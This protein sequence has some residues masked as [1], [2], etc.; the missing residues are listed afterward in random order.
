VLTITVVDGATATDFRLHGSL[1]ASSVDKVRAA[2]RDRSP[3][4]EVSLDLRGLTAMDRPGLG[5]ILGLIRTAREAGAT[6][7]VQ[8]SDEVCATLIDEGVGRLIGDGS[9]P[10]SPRTGR[11]RSSRSLPP[12]RHAPDAAP[13]I[14]TIKEAPR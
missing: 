10:S 13:S 11:R 2:Y 8:C 4:A 5:A 12:S 9:L 3:A 6:V 1:E 7:T 14:S